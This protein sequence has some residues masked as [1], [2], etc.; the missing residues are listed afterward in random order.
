V[1]VLLWIPLFC[2]PKKRFELYRLK[3]T[4]ENKKYAFCTRNRVE[5]EKKRTEHARD[6][7]ALCFA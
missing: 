2:A 5:H 4:I 6:N 7:I 1:V 3:S